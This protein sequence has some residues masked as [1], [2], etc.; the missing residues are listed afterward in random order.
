MYI[1]YNVHFKVILSNKVT[2]TLLLKQCSF[3]IVKENF[4]RFSEAHGGF[5][6]RLRKLQ[7][8]LFL[9]ARPLRGAGG[10]MSLATKKKKLFCGFF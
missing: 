1:L 6:T 3:D 10:N 8:V 7:K 2:P 9:V 4:S 5:I